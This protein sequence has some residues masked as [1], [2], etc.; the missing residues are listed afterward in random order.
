MEVNVRVQERRVSDEERLVDRTVDSL[1][2]MI[3]D[4]LGQ[5]QTSEAEAVREAAISILTRTVLR[6][7]DGTLGDDVGITDVPI[8]SEKVMPGLKELPDLLKKAAATKLGAILAN[9]LA[10][11]RFYNLLDRLP[12]G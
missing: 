11:I 12:P 2:Q 5:K 7:A 8:W 4:E 10:D 6:Y 9:E 1:A 3:E